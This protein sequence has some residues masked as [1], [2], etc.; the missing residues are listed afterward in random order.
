LVVEPAGGSGLIL[1]G[2]DGAHPRRICTV[3][4]RCLGAQ[5]PVWSPDGS[6]IAFA[7]PDSSDFG[8]LEPYVIY[9]DG[10]C[11]ACS[12]PAPSGSF[13]LDGWDPNLV[14]GFLPDGR[15]AV[16]IDVG[17]PPT[18]QLGAVNT[19]GIGFRP[20][21]ISGSWRQPAWS[22]T[23]RLA[24]VRR[25]NRKSE[26][27]AIDPRTRSARRLTRNGASSPTWS[28]D[29]RRLAVVH[30]GW[31]ELVGSRGGRVR[32]LTRGVAPAWAP[33]GK[34]LAFVGPHHRLFVIAARGGRPRPVG[35]VR[36]A[37]V[38]WQPV[39]GRTPSACR[40]P[41]GS[42]VVAASPDA[43]VTIDPA[44]VSQDPALNG[45][46][47]VL[48]CLTSDGR[49]RLL[50]SLPPSN[51]DNT[52]AAGLVVVAGDYA[53]LVNE[54]SD[55]HYGGSSGTVAVYDL[56]TGNAAAN[57]GGESG[58]CA[59]FESP[60]SGVERLVLAPDAATA[61]HTFFTYC[62]STCTTTEQIVANDSTGT[63]TLDN[64]TTTGPYTPTPSSLSQLSLS[65]HLL[66][67]SHAGS[68]R[69]AQLN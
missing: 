45:A 46:F 3:A 56:R 8:A 59:D 1:V 11:M 6:E 40:D 19:D 64:I 20:F 44:P 38:D 36:A 33:N 52:S 65:G 23:G 4:A 7:T 27:F 49:E 69:S 63:H 12:V 55:P 66:T 43:T 37:R 2:V 10:S 29:G 48:G 47:S 25:V 39:A 61:A 51:I 31:I 17:Y 16:S 35:H 53:A 34:Q 28:P 24:A 22:P 30:R 68:E 41:A 42:S 21:A 67:W 60:C 26:V 15:L 50:E 54:S 14:P 57:R 32:R 58:S 18:P 9:P 62:G 13:Y 5:D